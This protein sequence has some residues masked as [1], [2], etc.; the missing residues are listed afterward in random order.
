MI[1]EHCWKKVNTPQPPPMLP[2]LLSGDTTESHIENRRMEREYRE[3]QEAYEQRSRAAAAMIRATISP[4]DESFVKGVQDPAQICVI[5]WERLSPRENTSLQQTLC[6]EFDLLTFDEKENINAYL[7]K[8][9]DYQFNL[10]TTTL[11]ISETALS[12]KVLSSLPLTW[13]AQ[14]RH[15]TDSRMA[16]WASIEKSLR[17][18]QAEQKNISSKPASRAF[19]VSKKN[20]KDKRRKN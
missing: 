4:A 2:T 1:A 6:T 20:N 9:R 15:Y 14:I 10:E 11:S 3:D 5:L 18:I 8:L 12:S 17:N 16:T 7:K 13:R 19:A